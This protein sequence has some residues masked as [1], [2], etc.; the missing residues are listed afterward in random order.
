M[1]IF[2]TI[3]ETKELKIIKNCAE[4]AFLYFTMANG[5]YDNNYWQMLTRDGFKNYT[6]L[7]IFFF[8]ALS[9]EEIIQMQFET[10][11][12]KPLGEAIKQ[13]N[14]LC[15]KYIK[16]ELSE[17]QFLDKVKEINY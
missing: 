5:R 2:K 12:R 10:K 15:K 13:L 11:H 1:S 7:K 9:V 17:T 8:C 3:V 14:E 4:V 16:E 6:A